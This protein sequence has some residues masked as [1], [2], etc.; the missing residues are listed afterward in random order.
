MARAV[1][2]F[3]KQKGLRN[4]KRSAR[5][6]FS[7]PERIRPRKQV[8]RPAVPSCV[9]HLMELAVMRRERFS[10]GLKALRLHGESTQSGADS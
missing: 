8:A 3:A 10:R 5:M 9:W 4:S 2:A 7:W 6:L 1:I